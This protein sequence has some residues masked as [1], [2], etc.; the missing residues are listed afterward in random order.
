[1]N[2]FWECFEFAI[3]FS[4]VEFNTILKCVSVFTDT[5]LEN[6]YVYSQFYL[7]HFHS[8]FNNRIFS[9]M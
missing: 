4:N 6:K 8:I 5:I 9:G 3:M 1:M 2:I 7:Q